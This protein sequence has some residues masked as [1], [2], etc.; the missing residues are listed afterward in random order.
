MSKKPT[1]AGPNPIKGTAHI[2]AAARM[3]AMLITRKIR[4]AMRISKG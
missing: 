3:T 1:A 4:P 2:K